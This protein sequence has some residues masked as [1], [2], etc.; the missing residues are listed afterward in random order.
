MF[1]YEVS[2]HFIPSVKLEQTNF[3][4]YLLQTPLM[5]LPGHKEAISSVVWTENNEIFSS[6]WDHTIKLWDAELGGLKS[7]IVGNKS[8]FCISRSPLNQT[9]ITASADRHIRLYDARSQGT[10]VTLYAT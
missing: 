9:L 4:H 1:L 7:E 3:N 5:T 10:F 2:Q 6:S 8:F